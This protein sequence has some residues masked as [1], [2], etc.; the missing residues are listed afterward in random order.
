MSAGTATACVR[1][2]ER[3]ADASGL[4]LACWNAGIDEAWRERQ[5]L[6]SV[7]CSDHAS[8]GMYRLGDGETDAC[9]QCERDQLRA[10]VQTLQEHD[11]LCGVCSYVVGVA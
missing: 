4:C 11:C 10:L 6:K 5:V 3:Q 1:C 8:E 7:L 9:V 2:N